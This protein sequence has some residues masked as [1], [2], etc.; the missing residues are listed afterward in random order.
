M[1]WDDALPWAFLLFIAP[2]V[3]AIRSI[4]VQRR[5]RAKVELLTGKVSMLDHRIFR[6]DEG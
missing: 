3:M 6:L 1:D 2:F 4:V 5:L